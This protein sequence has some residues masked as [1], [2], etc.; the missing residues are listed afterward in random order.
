MKG[1]T[2]FSDGAER[3]DLL[4]TSRL[5]YDCP[6]CYAL[7]STGLN[8]NIFRREAP[9]MIQIFKSKFRICEEQ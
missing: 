2:V 7:I 9:R 4:W 1:S 5:L 6:E 3:L 8:L